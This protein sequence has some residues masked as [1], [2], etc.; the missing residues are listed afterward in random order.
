[1]Q[2]AEHLM[3]SQHICRFG[4]GGGRRVYLVGSAASS[5]S[6]VRGGGANGLHSVC[7]VQFAKSSGSDHKSP[8]W[9]GSHSTAVSKE[10]LM[11]WEKHSKY[12]AFYFCLFLSYLT[13][14]RKFFKTKNPVAH[15]KSI[16]QMEAI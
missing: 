4:G 6:L 10:Q 13:S 8:A 3:F 11:R 1:M 12:S 15:C 7:S 9:P 5:F 14:S 16:V 2:T